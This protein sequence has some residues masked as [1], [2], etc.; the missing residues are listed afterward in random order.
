[1]KLQQLIKILGI[2]IIIFFI[3]LYSTTIGGYYENKLSNQNI[4]TEEAIKRFEE[5]VKAGKQIIASNYIEEKKSYG[6]KASKLGIKMSNLIS[7]TFDKT[8]K[9]IFKQIENTISS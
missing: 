7:S 4:L 3:S 9:F 5:D 2:T 8:M 1:M 6:N